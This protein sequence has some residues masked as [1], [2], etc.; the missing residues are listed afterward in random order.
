MEQVCTVADLVDLGEFELFREAYYR[1]YG[2]WPDE[3][4]LERCFGACLAGRS[5]LPVYVRRYLHQPPFIL[6]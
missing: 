4:M 6:A 2:H 3:G 1:W 5:E